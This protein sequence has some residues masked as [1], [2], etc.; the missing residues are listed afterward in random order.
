MSEIKAKIGTKFSDEE[1]KK[2]DKSKAGKTQTKADLKGGASG[3]TLYQA[4]VI[5]PYC[6]TAQYVVESTNVYNY[7]T[8]A[9]C[10]NVFKA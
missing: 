4:L 9:G 6:G 8:C 3:Q 1:L 7:Y 10:G 2:V 5:C